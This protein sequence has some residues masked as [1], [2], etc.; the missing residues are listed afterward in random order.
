MRLYFICFLTLISCD[1]LI[2][3]EVVALP[4]LREVTSENNF[5]DS[6]DGTQYK[7]V[8]FNG[9]TVIAENMN[10]ATGESFCTGD[11]DETGRIY[12]YSEA[13]QVCPAGW[14]LPTVN[15]WRTFTSYFNPD[16]F[17]EFDDDFYLQYNYLLD[18]NFS[19]KL[20]GYQSFSGE[21]SK[22]QETAYFW[23]TTPAPSNGSIMAQ[24]FSPTTGTEGERYMKSGSIPSSPENRL[25]CMCFK[26]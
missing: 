2:E 26:D 5:T 23:S 20:A 21:I 24:F 9:I 18:E 22:E 25:S 19:I 3:D 10:Y 6:R 11:C 1:K 15:E 12:T 7:V 13:Q 16:Y 14:H 4:E 17:Q 8:S